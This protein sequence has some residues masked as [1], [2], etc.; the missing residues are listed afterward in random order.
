VKLRYTLPAKNDLESI[1]AYIRAQSPQ[2]ASRV[3]A[4]IRRSIEFLLLSPFIGVTVDSKGTR[5][6]TAS[7]YPYLVFY[8]VASEEVIIHAIRH[9]SRN[10]AAR[11]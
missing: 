5:R 6:I 10:P 7:P 1:L 2:S 8:E 11:T 4:H 9:M 3:N